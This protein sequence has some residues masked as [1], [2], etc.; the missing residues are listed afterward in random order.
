MTTNRRGFLSA[1]IKAA[2]GAMILPPALTY[3][4]HWHRPAASPLIVPYWYQ[5]ERLSTCFD[6][7]YLADLNRMLSLVGLPMK[8]VHPSP[9]L[10]SYQQHLE[11][12][13]AMGEALVGLEKMDALGMDYPRVDERFADA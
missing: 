3:A 8:M 6:D 4:R 12:R 2:A 11:Y 7:A 13:K 9:A 1:M 10:L 5:T